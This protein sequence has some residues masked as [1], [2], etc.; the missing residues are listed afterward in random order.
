MVA[1]AAFVMNPFLVAAKDVALPSGQV[2][3]LNQAQVDTMKGQA[4]VFY[5]KS[6]PE[7]HSGQAVVT[8][9]GELGGGHLYGTPEA[10]AQAMTNAGATVGAT[11][12][13]VVG[14]TA[15]AV[16]AGA[17]VATV[18]VVGIGAFA[19]AGGGGTAVAHPQ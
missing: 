4:G 6:T 19:S 9:P 7:T 1:L 2:I 13:T 8:L 3:E 14:A 11:S 18:A 10:L 17:T 5:S 16:I 12:S 15:A